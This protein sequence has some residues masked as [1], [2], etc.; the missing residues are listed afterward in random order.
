MNEQEAKAWMLKHLKEV[1]GP[2]VADIV[3]DLNAKATKNSPIDPGTGTQSDHAANAKLSQTRKGLVF[4]G[5]VAALGKAKMNVGAAIDYAEKTLKMPDVAKALTAGVGEEGG[6][7]IGVEHSD[8][9]IDLLTERAKIRPTISNIT[10]LSA[11]VAEVSR[12]TA[13]ATVSW[14][15]EIMK[16][17]ASQQGF[18]MLTLR[19]RQEKTLVPISNTLLRRG[20]PRVSNAIRFDTLR[21]MALGEDQVLLRSEGTEHRPKGL[22]YWAVAGN[23]VPMTATPTIATVFGDLGALVLKLAENNVGMTAPV[24]VLAP[25]TVV[26]L[27]T[28]LN[29]H[30]DPVFRSELLLGRLWGFPVTVTNHQPI[31][32]NPAANKSEIMLYDGDE[33]TLG[34]GPQLQV[35]LS[36]EGVIVDDA[37]NITSAFQQNMTFMRV[38]S[39][40]D[41]VARHAEAIAVLTGVTW[42]PGNIAAV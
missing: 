19:A 14:G 40:I 13:S 16:I 25:R 37:G 27:M 28:A 6:F 23:I 11:G 35:A 9:I 20:G 32:L 18:G 8:E 41:L 24:W 29:D 4:G 38:I 31:T 1:C 30:G 5:I 12:L 34:Q 17:P 21:A 42:A 15:G 39:E 22:R 10:D 33:F 3:G 2:I 36:E 26:G 7:T